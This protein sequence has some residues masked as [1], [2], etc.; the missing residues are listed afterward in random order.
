MSDKLFKLAGH[1]GWLNLVNLEAATDDPVYAFFHPTFQEYFASLVIDNYQVFMKRYRIFEIQWLEVAIL[2]LESSQISAVLKKELS[3]TITSFKEDKWKNMY[4]LKLLPLNIVYWCQSGEIELIA[5]QVYCVCLDDNNTPEKTIY[6]LMFPGYDKF[7]IESLKYYAPRETC[8]IINEV[9]NNNTDLELYKLLSITRLLEVLFK[10]NPEHE[11]LKVLIPKLLK[12]D[13]EQRA[14]EVAK[15]ALK[16]DNFRQIAA[17][18][19]VN[20]LL[21]EDEQYDERQSFDIVNILMDSKILDKVVIDKL[22][23]FLNSQ[24]SIIQFMSLFYFLEKQDFIGEN[25]NK[26]IKLIANEED[27]YESIDYAQLQDLNSATNNSTKNIEA[28]FM[29]QQEKQYVEFI[30][31]ICDAENLNF[32]NLMDNYFTRRL[33]IGDEIAIAK[34]KQT[35]FEAIDKMIE[36]LQISKDNMLRHI[37]IEILIKIETLLKQSII[38]K[39]EN[40]TVNLKDSQIQCPLAAELKQ[41]THK[42]QLQR[43]V[44]GFKDYVRRC[45]C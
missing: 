28:Y 27:T 3:D 12:D 19:L 10:I 25:I 40:L 43:L 42:A 8:D 2:W 29:E 37:C 41:I 1:L 11:C 16:N 35:N 31:L 14:I 44:F 5:R 22:T 4:R 39:L 7:I 9:I 17:D 21:N 45:S 24:N 20:A 38:D 23:S 15:I 34:I 6:K 26:S 33:Y 30:S 36:I 13:R 32:T 18:F